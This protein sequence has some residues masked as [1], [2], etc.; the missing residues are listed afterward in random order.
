[1]SRLASLMLSVAAAATLAACGGGGSDAPAPA[2]AALNGVAAVGRALAGA[3][4]EAR[5]RGGFTGMAT[6]AA[7][8]S[9]SIPF[10]SGSL[11]CV[12]RATS[13][14]T[15]LH[16]LARGSNTA[17]ITPVS[18][19]VVA[20][21]AGVSPA[22]Y[23]G[24]FNDAV[25]DGLTA[26]RVDAAHA[27]VVN[28]LKSGGVDFSAF[29]NLMTAP[30][31]AANGSTTGNAYD[32]ALDA[33]A[34]RMAARGL[35]LASLTDAVL[36]ASPANTVQTVNTPS[37]P[38]QALLQPAS[39]SCSA[40]RSGPYRLVIPKPGATA[41][42]FSTELI[43]VDATMGTILNADGDTGTFTPAAGGNCLFTTANGQFAVSP[44][45]VVVLR[46]LED[47]A[48]RLG[49]AFPEQAHALG[50]LAGAWQS[51]G[52][53]GDA[54]VFSAD[55]LAATVSATGNIVVSSYCADVVN[56]AAVAPHP[57]VTL[58]ANAAGGFTLTD[59][60]GWTERFFAYRAGNGD[61]ML[62]ELMHTG[63]FGLWTP[64]RA[65]GAVA[66][67]SRLTS[68]GTWMD[69]NLQSTSPFSFTDYTT[70]ASSGATWTRVS[71]FDG[72]SETLTANS[73]RAGWVTRAEGNA[74]TAGGGM[75]VVR[76][77]NGLV[78]RGMGLTA[79]S[80]PTLAGGAYFLSVNQQ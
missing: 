60:T 19:L 26:A 46:S 22:G 57:A 75:V 56:C 18:Q 27:S 70:T 72:H 9:Y 54:S 2:T 28:T 1:M 53:D 76:G 4:V 68:W 42:Q 43:Q 59:S 30:L 74:P 29:G 6:A 5:C 61:L 44:A 21:L 67:G 37:L 40:L 73:P 79:L 55:S 36:R 33:L 63:G 51:L 39:A 49:V 78:V 20:H 48:M 50:D 62:V 41:G 7:N 32:Q 8:G 14:A 69:P 12:L 10:T 64:Q 11:P 47:G 24:S 52:Y 65:T 34:Q 17:H 38:P 66:L 80:M 77:F 71:A 25:A 15:V 58:S 23:Y 13:G 31:V 45:G 3:T 35:T 16:S